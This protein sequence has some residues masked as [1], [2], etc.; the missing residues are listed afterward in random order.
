[1]KS[2]KNVL[3]QIV[4]QMGSASHRPSDRLA[5]MLKS[6]LGNLEWMIIGLTS[7]F[8][9][10]TISIGHSQSRQAVTQLKSKPLRFS[11]VNC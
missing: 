10:L 11:L 7:C 8:L 5:S 1:M 4:L 2:S 9:M 3:T 6:P